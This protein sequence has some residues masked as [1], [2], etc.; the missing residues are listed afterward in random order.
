MR[1]RLVSQHCF[2]TVLASALSTALFAPQNADQLLELRNDATFQQA[3][4][5]K[6]LKTL[7]EHR[8]DKRKVAD[9]AEDLTKENILR[10]FHLKGDSAHIK[11][12]AARCIIAT[13]H[14]GYIVFATPS[15]DRC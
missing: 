10:C 6:R 1:A 11:P 4:P 3:T 14:P 9:A 5:L 7:A 13:C 8:R 12:L 2:L 15:L